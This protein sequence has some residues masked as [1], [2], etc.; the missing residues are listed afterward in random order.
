V[1]DLGIGTVVAV[2]TVDI[3]AGLASDIPVGGCTVANRSPAWGPEPRTALAAE[4]SLNPEGRER[5]EERV[6][7]VVDT[8][9]VPLL[10]SI[11]AAEV[12]AAAGTP[13]APLP[14]NTSVAVPRVV[15][16]IGGGGVPLL[17]LWLLSVVMCLK[18]TGPCPPPEPRAFECPARG[19]GKDAPERR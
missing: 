7:A 11:P 13:A 9:V 4:G 16:D 12:E 1:G 14:Y 8:P 5:I 10:C 3:E 18:V 15:G 17:V 2:E 6:E 19:E